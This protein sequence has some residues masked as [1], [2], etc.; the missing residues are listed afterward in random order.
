VGRSTRRRRGAEGS[1]RGATP[2]RAELGS[3]GVQLRALEKDSDHRWI[4]RGGCGIRRKEAAASEIH[5]R[6]VSWCSPSSG[7]GAPL[8]GSRQPWAES[9]EGVRRGL[10]GRIS[11]PTGTARVA[12][13]CFSSSDLISYIYVYPVD[14]DVGTRSGRTV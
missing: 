9:L 12:F 10:S 13:P 3:S 14:V 7:T 11:R 6:G 2:Q 5:V 1:S 4:H 8:L